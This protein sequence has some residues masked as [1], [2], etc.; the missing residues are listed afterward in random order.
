MALPTNKKI[1][2]T[3]LIRDFFK[4]S[5]ETLPDFS[6]QFKMLTDLD[7]QQ[8]ASAIARSQGL[9]QDQCDFELIEYQSFEV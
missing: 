8:L 5:G 2:V 1:S 3:F 4:V 9:T 7:K 6:R